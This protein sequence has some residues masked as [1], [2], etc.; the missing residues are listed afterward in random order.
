VNGGPVS[1]DGSKT[2]RSALDFAYL[3]R[4]TLGDADL[5]IELLHAFR[6]Q[7]ESILRRLRGAQ[8]IEARERADFAHLL[9]GSARAIGAIR[10]GLACETYE[11]RLA[12]C[13]PAA[14]D[15]LRDLA[16]A[17]VEALAPIDKS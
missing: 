6:A 1:R 9:K 13:G 14:A 16:A 4:Q 2:R 7:A 15:A 8:P 10:V 5:E 17:V 12:E 11:A 3:A